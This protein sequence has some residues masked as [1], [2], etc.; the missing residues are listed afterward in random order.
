MDKEI[1]DDKEAWPRGSVVCKHKLSYAE[2]Q[3]I[4]QR[5]DNNKKKFTTL[6]ANSA[7]NANKTP[8]SSTSN[9]IN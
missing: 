5:M 7:N 2:W 1:I 9:I 4:S 3:V 8:T 6:N